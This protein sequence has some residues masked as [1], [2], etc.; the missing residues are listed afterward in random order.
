MYV[1]SKTTF[2]SIGRTLSVESASIYLPLSALGFLRRPYTIPLT[3]SQGQQLP[4]QGAPHKRLLGLEQQIL[5]LRVIAF[6]PYCTGLGSRKVPAP[7][8]SLRRESIM[9]GHVRF[10]PVVCGVIKWRAYAQ[11]SRTDIP[12]ITF[13]LSC[14]RVL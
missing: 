11:R 5:I 8:M 14:G 10:M 1:I 9:L 7:G 13:K 4:V 2:W 6:A 12:M 3:R